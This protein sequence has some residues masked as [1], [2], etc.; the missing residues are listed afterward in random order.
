MR[1]D[2]ETKWVIAAVGIGAVTWLATA[3]YSPENSASFGGASV[4]RR[5]VALEPVLARPA[6]LPDPATFG[7]VLPP[8][9]LPPVQPRKQVK[10]PPPPPLSEEERRGI[11][12]F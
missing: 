1:I 3:F 9:P 11:I 2:R 12:T 6:G 7:T 10:E 4:N 8:E 5:L